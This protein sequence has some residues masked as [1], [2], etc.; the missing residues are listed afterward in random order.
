MALY[1]SVAVWVSMAL[2]HLPLARL[3]RST[4]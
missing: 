4:P 1:I 3:R 2:A